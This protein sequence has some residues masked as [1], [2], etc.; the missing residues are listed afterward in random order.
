MVLTVSRVILI[1][2]FLTMAFA[3][4]D[5]KQGLFAALA[6][7]TSGFFIHNFNG[8]STR[9]ALFFPIVSFTTGFFG[10]TGYPMFERWNVLGQQPD[11]G[12]AF[13]WRSL[14]F[15]PR[16]WQ[17]GGHWIS[18]CCW[19]CLSLSLLGMLCRRLEDLQVVFLVVVVC[20]MISMPITRFHFDH[21]QKRRWHVLNHQ[22]LRCSYFSH[23]VNLLPMSFRQVI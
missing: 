14:A 9:G 8:E 17:K 1:S 11:L 2:Y 20:F 23:A 5:H 16:F 6:L 4:S 15:A 19:I 7:S 21:G 13:R 12:F 22:Q 18:R 10:G 3:S